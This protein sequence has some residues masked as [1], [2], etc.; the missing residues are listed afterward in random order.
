MRKKVCF[1]LI[2][3]ILVSSLLMG[4]YSFM[5]KELNLY[6]RNEKSWVGDPMPYFDGK[7]FQVF[8]LE[9]LRNGEK[10]FHPWS[11]MTTS[12]FHSYQDKGIVLPYVNDHE[13]MELA[14]G[15]GSVI[16][17]QEG[18]YHAF[19]TGHN[20]ALTP[21]EAVMH[22]T[23]TDLTTWDKRPDDT[24]WSS[25][26]YEKND[27]RDPYVVFNAEANNYWM[28]LTT[29]QNDTGVIAKYT[30]EDLINWQDEGVLFEND[31]GTDS[32]LECPTLIEFGG[33]WYLTF[34]DQW[35][36]RIV[37][38]RVADNPAGPFEKPAEDSWDGN[39]FY[40]GRLEK[41]QENLYVF[42]W[43]PTKVNYDDNGNYDWAGNL[44]VHQLIQKSDGT[45]EA[46][47]PDSIQKA[48]K[49]TKTVKM[50]DATD[51]VIYEKKQIEFEGKSLESAR[52]EANDK[53]TKISGNIRLDVKNSKFG[54]GFNAKG[55]NESSLNIVVDSE[56]NE[57][58]FYAVPYHQAEEAEPETVIQLDLKDRE[59]IDFQLVSEDNVLVLYLNNKKAMSTRMFQMKGQPWEMFSDNSKIEVTEF[60]Q[61]H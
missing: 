58:A 56:K 10:G 38:Y 47:L 3:A 45:L 24:F 5:K 52:F 46:Q 55:T 33:K 11:L 53:T 14:L 60:I 48:M 29:R 42:G 35:P 44:V 50:I 57:A 34:S 40:A 28:L 9:D 21:K 12:N 19:Y 23:S 8:Y 30:S 16:Q 17:D 32:N 49:T 26:D 39:G 15:T 7:K 59:S 41:D 61:Q 27:F 51:G 31:M 25:E 22:A 6:P 20:G 54:F 43:V 36:E 37:H 4:G 18:L 2:A 1:S 13:S